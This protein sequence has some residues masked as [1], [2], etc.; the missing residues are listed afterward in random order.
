MK[1][2]LS[3]IKSLYFRWSKCIRSKIIPQFHT[4]S[5]YY[6]PPPTHTHTS[7]KFPNESYRHCA[8]ST[9]EVRK[10]TSFGTKGHVGLHARWSSTFLELHVP[11]L[12]WHSFTPLHRAAENSATFA[13]FYRLT[14][15]A[16]TSLPFL[17][18]K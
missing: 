11:R 1:K 12:Q 10:Q 7:H 18:G 5:Y 3:C 9:D 13:Y 4:L 17:S 16:A 8:W 6:P 14:T 15:K 2:C